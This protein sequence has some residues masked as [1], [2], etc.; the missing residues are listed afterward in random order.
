MPLPG[1]TP[2]A[3]FFQ[4]ER[5]L[6]LLASWGINTFFGPEVENP[7]SHTPEALLAKQASWI[8]ATRKANVWCVL[9]RP[10]AVPPDN[11]IG[12]CLSSDEPNG[13]GILPLDMRLQA[14]FVDYRLR[15]PGV[16]I[17]LSLAGDKVHSANFLRAH[18][19][20]LY[21]D[22]AALCDVMT[23]NF[24]S[25]NRN[26]TRYPMRFTAEACKKLSILTGK[27]VWAWIEANDQQLPPPKPTDGVNRAPTPEEIDDTV[28][29]CVQAFVPAIGF[30][31]TCDSGKYGWGT[32]NTD[33]ATRGDSY[34]PLIDRN[35]ISMQ[36]QYDK[37]A[38]I[39]K[40]LAPPPV[41]AKKMLPVEVL[42]VIHAEGY[43]SRSVTA[44][45][46]LEE[47]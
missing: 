28:L 23:V 27:P 24:Y 10:P 43:K 1:T 15:Y 22:Y 20:Q 6:S 29:Q 34:L 19:S 11:C 37:V 16:P 8:E 47:V 25:A 41:P 42:T 33:F 38:E 26:A 12:I 5:N 9:K 4:P 31:F 2:V 14:E 35:G 13:K 45:V 18:E 17:F 30:F 44:K 32:G 39:A 7:K 46:E 3:A 40:R 36:P 21:L